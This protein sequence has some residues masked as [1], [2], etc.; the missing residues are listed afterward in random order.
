MA[1]FIVY[2][3]G[4]IQEPLVN[5][6]IINRFFLISVSVTTKPEVYKTTSS[7]EKNTCYDYQKLSS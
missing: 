4:I 2:H 6:S 1:S 7:E 5:D 3:L